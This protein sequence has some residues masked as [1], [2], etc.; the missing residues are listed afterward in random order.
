MNNP[1]DRPAISVILPCHNLAGQIGAAIS[2]LHA[3]RFA[4]FEVLVIDD[5]STD[6]TQGAVARAMASDSRFRLI[7]A[8]H[9]GLSVARNIG[10]DLARGNVIAFLD[11]DDRYAPDFLHEHHA[12]LIAHDA[13]WTAS[14]LTLVQPDGRCVAHSAI[15]T[16]PVPQ[17]RARWLPLHD[18]CDVAALFPS[19]W[20]K[21]YRRDL[22]GDLRFRPGALFEDH[23]FYWALACKTRR[24][25][26]LPRDLYRYH[27]GRQGQITA[28]ADDGILQHLDRLAEVSHT[29][30]ASGMTRQRK[31]LSQLATRAVDE[32]L[33]NAPPDQVRAR[34]LDK[35]KTLFTVQGW[36][37]DR[38]HATDIAP[39]PAPAID[40]EMRLSVV[41]TGDRTGATDAALHAQTLPV[42]E[43]LRPPAAAPL[44][45]ILTI[46]SRADSPWV[47]I[48]AQGDMPAPHWAATCLEAAREH[49]ASLVVTA[50]THLAARHGHDCGIAQ[51]GS[52]PLVAADLSAIVLRTADLRACEGNFVH[53]TGL[54]ARVAAACL[55]H[56]M[57]GRGQVLHLSLSLITLA[58][59]TRAPLAQTAQ[60]LATAPA[61]FC[62][63]GARDRAAI[64]AHLAQCRLAA[65]KTR[66]RR[67]SIA[68]GAGLARLRAGLPPTGAAPHI[69]PYLRA[70]L[71]QPFA[72]RTTTDGQT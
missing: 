13:P 24:I 68:L 53:Y 19:V 49:P 43:T 58:R 65:A 47:A 15:H 40:P 7:A 38:T 51:N 29:A 42:V 54:P 16:A 69:G 55:A 6:G 34:F 66:P 63:I 10:L 39:D 8:A 31:G 17:G 70:C 32:R 44:L 56:Q 28:R 26:Y 50:C 1:K 12:E 48:L 9:R 33:R 41:L 61:H 2:S 35:A 18:A 14:A 71:G 46:A 72:S 3:Q 52:T 67:Y 37:W 5:G 23:P 21:L 22:I 45:H 25:R 36:H 30:S 59:R 11:G 57:A 62:P 64:F 20:N 4:D 27:H 60:A